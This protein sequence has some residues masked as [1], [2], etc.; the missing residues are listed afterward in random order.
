M[1]VVPFKRVEQRA[2][3]SSLFDQ[4]LRAQPAHT[5]VMLIAS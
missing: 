3:V 4:L 1:Q 5:T 2:K